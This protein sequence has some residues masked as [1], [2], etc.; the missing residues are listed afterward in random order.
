M[1]K[2]RNYA[3]VAVDYFLNKTLAEYPDICKCEKC[4]LDIKACALNRLKPKYVVTD[5][6]ETYARISSELE[7]QEMVDVIE[8]IMTGIEI[9]SKNPRH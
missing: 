3:E 7:K 2:L 1:Y 5:E 4:K 8:A 9:V 6:G